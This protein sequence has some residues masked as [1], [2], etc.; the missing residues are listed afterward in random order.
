[1][2]LG[3][4]VNYQLYGQSEMGIQRL[5]AKDKKL[6]AG[7]GFFLEGT[8][9][10]AG[11]LMG[12][13]RLWSGERNFNELLNRMKTESDLQEYYEAVLINLF[14]TAVNMALLHE[15]NC[16][17]ITGALLSYNIDLS[18]LFKRAIQFI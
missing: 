15:Q 2:S 9:L 6:T 1:M 3:S 10:G 18:F 13:G 17:F 11:F 7:D 8:S 14:L 4:G 5:P 12:L 16:I